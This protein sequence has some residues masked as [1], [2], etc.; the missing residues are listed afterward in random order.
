VRRFRRAG[1]AALG[2]L[3]ISGATTVVAHVLSADAVDLLVLVAVLIVAVV[4]GV[5]R[6]RRG[7]E[8]VRAALLRLESLGATATVT[9]DPAET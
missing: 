4:W 8:P 7:G 3:A 5:R 9:N 6:V 2:L 1:Y